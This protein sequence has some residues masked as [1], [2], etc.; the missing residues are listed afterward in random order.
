[1]YYADYGVLIDIGSPISH[2]YTFV[3]GSIDVRATTRSPYDIR[4]ELDFTT[5][6]P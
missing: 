4:H 3:Y 5:H 2:V 6:D 1:M